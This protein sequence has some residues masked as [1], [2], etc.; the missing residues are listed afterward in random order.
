MS[1]VTAASADRAALEAFFHSPLMERM[2]SADRLLREYAFFTR[3]PAGSAAALAGPLAYEPVLVQGVADC[4][5]EKDGE[6]FLVD[7]KTDRHRTPEQLRDLY[8]PQL[9]LYR[10]ALQRRLGLPVARCS[11]YAF[12]LGREIEVF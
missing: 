1:E 8:A 10:E 3:I 11:L 7:Y 5:I 12:A 4:V 6:L 2:L 9:A